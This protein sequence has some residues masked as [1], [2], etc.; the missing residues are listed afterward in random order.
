MD[1]IAIIFPNLKGNIGDFAILDAMLRDIARRW[2]DAKRDVFLPRNRRKDEARLQ[3]FRDAGAPHFE[4]AGAT[5]QP[6]NSRH[7]LERFGLR[8]TAQTAR[9]GLLAEASSD[10]AAVFAGY[11]AIF[12]AGGDQW[13]GRLLGRAMFGSL[14][15]IR[16]VNPAIYAFPFSVHPRI[17]KFNSPAALRRMFGQIVAPLPIR[18]SIS[19]AMMFDLG[20]VV[21]DIPDCVFSLTEAAREVAPMP[22]RDGERV[23]LAATGSAQALRAATAALVPYCAVE[24][25][26]TC[27]SED[28]AALDALGAEFDIPVRA[29]M[30]WQE[31]VAEFASA[32]VVV[33]NRLHGLILGALAGALLLPLTD[34]KKSEAFALDTGVPWSAE[35]PA[36]LTHVDITACVDRREAM[37][38]AVR[39]YRDRAVETLAATRFG[40]SE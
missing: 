4:I 35:S 2:P 10:E 37:V 14:A 20:L 27:V 6:D 22:D 17:L 25:L 15:A 9:I 16:A 28:G 5:F 8:R 29:P 38:G 30:T 40:P 3:A 7:P 32:Q 33:T 24:L 18:D 34:R 12:I 26:T 19:R 21:A 36:A 23:I 39:G 11:D 13:N 1:S 31:T